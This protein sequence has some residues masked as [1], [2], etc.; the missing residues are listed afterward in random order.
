[1]ST[2]NYSSSF[3]GHSQGRPKENTG[4]SASSIGPLSRIEPTSL[5]QYQRTH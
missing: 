4:L 3:Q 2:I 1:L 5:F